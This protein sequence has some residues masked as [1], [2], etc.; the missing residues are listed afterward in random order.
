MEQTN[1]N[2]FKGPEFVQVDSPPARASGNSSSSVFAVIIS[3]PAYE[4]QDH[5]VVKIATKTLDAGSNPAT[6]SWQGSGDNIEIHRVFGYTGYKISTQDTAPADLRNW[7]PWFPAGVVVE[8]FKAWD[9][10]TQADIWWLGETLTFTG[11]DD[12]SSLRFDPTL[13]ITQAVWK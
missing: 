8:I 3:A 7:T 13:K 12:K 9:S 2:R 1:K 5:Y 11:S 4:G 6:Y 10:E